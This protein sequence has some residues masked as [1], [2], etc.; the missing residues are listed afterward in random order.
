LIEDIFQ[1]TQD[2]NIHKDLSTVSTVTK[3]LSKGSL[4]ASIMKTLNATDS[5]HCSLEVSINGPEFT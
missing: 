1:S 5:Q 2:G 4:C 3:Y